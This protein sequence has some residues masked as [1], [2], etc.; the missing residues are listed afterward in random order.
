[1]IRRFIVLAAA[2]ALAI[3]GLA[4]VQPAQAAPRGAIC[5]VSGKAKI[6]PG[7]TTAAKT[8]K[9]T[10][11]NVKVTNCQVG[12]SAAPGVPKA[13]NGI[14]TTLPNPATTKGS[15]ASSSLKNISATIKWST[16]PTTTAIFSTTSITGETVVQGKVTGGT[17]P[18]LKRNDILAGNVVF[19]PANLNMNCAT[20]P[21]TAVNF[22][23]VIGA[24]S[25]I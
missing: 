8:Q 10:L 2:G 1:M 4:T 20:V 6:F 12:N 17:D 11:T 18:N 5:Q 19:T 21:V 16:G 24:G 9:V 25:P 22:S 14:V 3:A 13:R 15:C 7:L 23:G